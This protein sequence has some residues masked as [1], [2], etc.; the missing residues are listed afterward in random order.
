[1]ARTKLVLSSDPNT[2]IV[3]EIK[4]LCCG[5]IL[6]K[7][8]MGIEVAPCLGLQM[9][10]VCPVSDVNSHFLFNLDVAIASI[11]I[12]V[13]IYSLF[14]AKEFQIRVVINRFR[15]KKL[16]FLVVAILSITFGAALLPYIPGEPVAL[17]GYPVFWEILATLL[18]FEAILTGY[19]V[20]ARPKKLNGNQISSLYNYLPHTTAKYHNLFEPLLKELEFIWGDLLKKSLTNNTVRR[21]FCGSFI[22]KD[23]LKAASKSYYLNYQTLDFI[24]KN[25]L[26]PN[27]DPVKSFFRELVLQGLS[28]DES[29]IADDIESS[30]KDLMQKIIR[31]S[32][33]GNYIFG[34]SFEYDVKVD[35]IDKMKRFVH[36]LEMFLGRKYH[37]TE[38]ASGY[39]KLVDSRA[40]ECIFSFLE[41]NFHSL[42]NEDKKELMGKLSMMTIDTSIIPNDSSVVF[43]SKLY[44]LIEQFAAFRDWSADRGDRHVIISL[45]RLIKDNPRAN[46]IFRQKLQ[47][48][49]IGSDEEPF[50]YN[51]NGFYPMM[52]PIYIHTY[53]WELFSDNIPPEDLDMHMKII[54]KMHERLPQFLEGKTQEYL[55]GT[56]LPSDAEGKEI[57]R[58]KALKALKSMF[59]FGVRYDADQNS[60]TYLYS[61][62][63]HKS[64]L[65]LNES[66]RKGRPIIRKTPS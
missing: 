9:L 21:M 52:V 47:D 66:V 20:I 58:V 32:R 49:I 42:S 37:Y 34:R 28:E 27:I 51:L 29:V 44:D 31:Q 53:G 33:L 46:N 25:K 41:K 7:V 4:P 10:S 59:P 18:M 62:E 13:S 40:I 56:P 1:M 6:E 50:A 36:I 55:T 15:V 63:E 16:T 26:S 8:V 22:E 3:L 19:S 17:I 35:S 65:L 30:Y 64:T 48:K 43:A 14:L 2:S 12:V 57:V 61:S 23:F 38:D 11:A 5:F 45:F 54:T 24:D 39:M 60:I